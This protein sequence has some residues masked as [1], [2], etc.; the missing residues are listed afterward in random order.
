MENFHVYM[1][2]CQVATDNC[3]FSMENFKNQCTVHDIGGVIVSEFSL[4]VEDYW[5]KNSRQFQ[6]QPKTITLMLA[7]L[8]LSTHY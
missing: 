7:A 2:N 3:Q 1:S 8:L 5:F 4:Y 6:I